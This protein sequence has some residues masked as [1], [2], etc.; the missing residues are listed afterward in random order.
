MKMKANN[1]RSQ[2]S[3]VNVVKIQMVIAN[4]VRT[5]HK[6]VM[7]NVNHAKTQAMHNV[8]AVQRTLATKAPMVNATRVMKMRHVNLLE[9]KALKSFNF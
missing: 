1:K 2:L 5:M 4:V 7:V 8:T 3:T 6:Q 9:I